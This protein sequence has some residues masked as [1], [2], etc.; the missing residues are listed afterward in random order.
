MFDLIV[1]VNEGNTKMRHCGLNGKNLKIFFNPISFHIGH[2]SNSH[3]LASFSPSH[4]LTPE[5]TTS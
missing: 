3:P 1:F 2:F 5:A 4:S